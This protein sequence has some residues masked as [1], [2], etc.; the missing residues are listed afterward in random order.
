LAMTRDQLFTG[1]AVLDGRAKLRVSR[2]RLEAVIV[3]SEGDLNR[4]IVQ[5][6]PGLL[7]EAGIVEGRLPYP[8]PASEGWV[9][10]RGVAPEDGEDGRI[11]FAVEIPGRRGNSEEAPGEGD[12]AA[13]PL[14]VDPHF[15]GNVVNV[16]EGEVLARKLAPTQG[17]P[18]TDVFGA[19]IE[20]RPGDTVAFKPGIGVAISKDGT[21]LISTLDGKLDFEDGEKVSV[22]DEWTINGS[23]DASTGHVTFFGRQL[24]VTGSVQTGFRVKAHG[25][26]EVYGNIEDGTKV[27]VLENLVVGG[28]IRADSTVVQVEGNVVCGAVEYAKLT[29]GGD[30]EVRDYILASR[31]QAHGDVWVVKGKGLVAGG[32]V[33]AG[34]SLAARVVG[35]HANVQTRIYAGHDPVVNDQQQK[36]IDEVATWSSLALQVQEGLETLERLEAK[37]LLDRKRAFIKERL[38]KVAKDLSESLAE[39]RKVL[40]DLEARLVQMH[41]ATVQ[42]LECG[43]AKTLVKIDTVGMQLERDVTSAVRFAYRNGEMVMTPLSNEDSP[44]SPAPLP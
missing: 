6:L 36:T 26:L 31:C 40:S 33:M 35:T 22:H 19:P 17:V 38:T 14:Y 20:P 5:A 21:E 32:T 8:E 12:E 16:H 23:V 4:E 9:M 7:D 15:L 27:E 44:P 13:D 34:R 28:I 29:I 1:C 2:D 10:A 43:Y 11:E 30:L 3:P 42:V 25:D 37:G 39:A 24:T 18:G 41:A